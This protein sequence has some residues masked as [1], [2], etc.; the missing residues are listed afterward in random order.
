MNLVKHLFETIQTN[1]VRKSLVMMQNAL[2]L[3]AI[4]QSFPAGYPLFVNKK[5]FLY[6]NFL[7][8]LEVAVIELMNE[9]LKSN[10]LFMVEKRKL[11]LIK[12]MVSVQS[13]TKSLNFMVT[14]SIVIQTSFLMKTLY[15]Q[16][17]KM[18]TIT[19]T[20]KDIRAR[21]QQCVQDLQDKG[22]TVEIIW[23]KDWQV[24]IN[25]QPEIKV[26]LKQHRTYTHFE[27]YLNQNQIIQYIQDSCFFGFVEC[28]IEVPD[29]LKDY[30][31]EITLIFKNTEVCLNDVGQHMQEY[32]KEHKIKDI[33]HRLLIGSYFGKKIGLST[34][35]L[36]WYLNH[37]LVI[38]HIYTVVEYIPN[39][40]LNSFMM[41]VTQARLDGDH[42]ND[43]ALI[44]ETMKLIGNSSYGKLI[45]NKEKHHDIVYV[46]E[47]EIGTEITDEHFYN[48]TE[49][50]DG[51]YEVEKTKKKINLDL[52]FYLGVFIHNYAKL[53]M[54]EFYYNFLDYYLPRE[55]FEILEMDM[56][57]NYLGIT[58]EN[59]EDFIKP[60][61][62]E[63]FE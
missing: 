50:P 42:D 46:N 1:H 19:M 55:D 30:F 56:D 32:A 4:G 21:D 24:L 20:V 63:E 33:P 23:E 35:L 9:T 40:A 62:R 48:L 22:Y 26:Y 27:K 8:T 61:L 43:K 11:D 44:A 41:Q 39:A 29:H 12:S 34:P 7:S 16:L 58:G 57:S 17:S 53:R 6:V 59:V 38:T 49:L 5:S 15:T 18:K 3:W 14:T 47:S 54:L 13:S 31:S 25:Q 28:D 36:K 2:Y 51:Y 45:T 37:D 60:E 10:L 52:P